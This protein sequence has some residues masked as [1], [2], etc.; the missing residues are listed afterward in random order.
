M[1]KF[2]VFATVGLVLR[3]DVTTGSR[4]VMEGQDLDF[5]SIDSET[6]LAAFSEDFSSPSNRFDNDH[7]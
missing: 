1:R 7:V 3:L 5:V 2:L 4:L 6:T